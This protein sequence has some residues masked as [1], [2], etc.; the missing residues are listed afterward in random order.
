KTSERK[1]VRVSPG[2]RVAVGSVTMEVGALA[3]TVLV[4]GDAPMIQAQT[5]DRSFTVAKESVENLPV[6]G[7]N[8]ATFAQLTPGVI[9]AGGGGATRAD[10]ARTNYLL[11]GIS[12]VDT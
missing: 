6:T 12:S 10:G 7:R 4:S 2:D 8:F 5:G 1:G 9:A 11:D 3:E